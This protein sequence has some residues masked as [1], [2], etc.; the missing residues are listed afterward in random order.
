MRGI[1]KKLG[2]DY[3]TSFRSASE[4]DYQHQPTGK[5]REASPSSASLGEILKRIKLRGKA[6]GENHPSLCELHVQAAEML[7]EDSMA[8]DHLFMALA[9]IKNRGN[10]ISPE[11]V[12]VL[13]KLGALHTRR[14]RFIQAQEAFRR[15]AE[16]CGALESGRK[17][18]PTANYSDS[19]LRNVLSKLACE[20]SEV[21]NAVAASLPAKQAP[22]IRSSDTQTDVEFLAPPVTFTVS[23]EQL[24]RLRSPALRTAHELQKL[25]SYV[26]NGEALGAASA[27][28]GVISTV[29]AASPSISRRSKGS[30]QALL[31]T[32]ERVKNPLNTSATDRFEGA[33]QREVARILLEQY[34]IE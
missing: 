9:N 27:T 16:I 24:N 13:S 18:V 1:A 3:E 15:A 2:V 11:A 23:K 10:E 28:K 31:D 22:Q 34:S 21:A 32:L 29:A 26:S 4:A 5:S 30:L 14:G 12:S 33:T 17:P 6:L 25:V 19:H 7:A 20:R 8:E